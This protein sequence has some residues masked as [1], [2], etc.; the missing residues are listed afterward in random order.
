M[1]LLV[2]EMMSSVLG[3]VTYSTSLTG[4]I[5]IGGLLKLVM[6]HRGSSQQL[7]LSCCNLW[8]HLISNTSTNIKS[9]QLPLLLILTLKNEQK[10]ERKKKTEK[11][12]KEKEL[13]S[14]KEKKKIKKKL[15]CLIKCLVIFVIQHLLVTGQTDRQT[16]WHQEMNN[17]S[18]PL[19]PPPPPLLTVLHYTI[20]L[21]DRHYYVLLAG[22]GFR[23]P[24]LFW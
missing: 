23:R 7:M 9:N 5:L 3:K 20:W 18:L 22:L 12:N 19:S 2:E 8:H 15:S 1:T 24:C 14:F 13:N 10:K 4:R 6:A 11:I 21:N 17:T 16:D